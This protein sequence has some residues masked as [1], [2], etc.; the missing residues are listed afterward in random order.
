MATRKNGQFTRTAPRLIQMREVHGLTN[1]VDY[2]AKERPIKIDSPAFDALSLQ[3]KKF[4]L[5]YLKDFNATE[6]AKRAKYSRKTAYSQGGRLLKNVEVRRALSEVS[7]ELLQGD[8]ADIQELIQFWTAIKRGNIKDVCSW[9]K[10]GF[11]FTAS[12][13]EMERATSQLIK[14]V[15]VTEKT[16]AKGDWS[17]TKTEVELHDALEASEKLGK[18]WGI[19]KKKVDLG[20]TSFERW[21]AQVRGIG[22]DDSQ[23]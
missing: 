12:S 14:K 2:A 20:G 1:G 19:F 7:G 5:E 17:E 11:V 8:V 23:G 4:V 6:A 9:T 16:S 3:K 22:N 21:L 15:K 13:D 18:Y 10:D